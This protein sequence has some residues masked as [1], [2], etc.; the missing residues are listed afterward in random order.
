MLHPF[1]STLIQRPDL[2]ME[3]VSGYLEL[4][5]QEVSQAGAMLIKRYITWA[6]VAIFGVVF[7]LFSGVALMLGVLLNQFHWVLLAVPGGALLIMLMA[8]A[9]TKSPLVQEQFKELKSQIDSDMQA[10]KAQV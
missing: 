3:H 7:V 5:R 8:F 6:L 4:L 1:F 2:L 9:K 10:M